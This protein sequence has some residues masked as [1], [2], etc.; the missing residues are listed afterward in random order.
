MC[1]IFIFY[2]WNNCHS[3]ATSDEIELMRKEHKEHLSD[4]AYGYLDLEEI[5]HFEGLDYFPFDSSFQI[6]ARFT[7]K[8]GRSF[9]MPT[10]TDRKPWYRRYGYL[11]FE[12]KGVTC[13]LEVYQN[14]TLKQKKEHRKHLFL[15]MRDK[16]SAKTT[17]G[18]GRFLDL[19][20]PKEDSLII[21]FNLLYNPYCAYSDRY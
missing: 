20:I 8:K 5:E 19:I 17:Y 18:G 4:T 21:D 12:V 11:D 3:Q 2:I 6:K 16:T 14:I 9:E 10:S 13:R 1:S 15:P 7:K